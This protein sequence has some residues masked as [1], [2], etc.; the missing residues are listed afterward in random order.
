MR[1]SEDGSH[2]DDRERFN[3]SVVPDYKLE[4]VHWNIRY[5]NI[6]S[7]RVT[8]PFALINNPRVGCSLQHLASFLVSIG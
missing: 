8:F 6:P 4:S 2:K 5:A 1:R 7:I 3:R